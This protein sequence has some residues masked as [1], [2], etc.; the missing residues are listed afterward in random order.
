M[1]ELEAK[2]TPTASSDL[3]TWMNDPAM[4][5]MLKGLSVDPYEAAPNFD[6]WFDTVKEI[7]SS[8]GWNTYNPL[9]SARGPYQIL[10]GSYPVMLRRAIRAYKKAGVEPP[11]SFTDALADKDRDPADLSETE[12]RRLIFLDIQQRPQKNKEGVGTDKLIMDLAKGNWGAG[13]DLYLDHHHTD[14]TDQPTLKRSKEKFAEV[15]DQVVVPFKSVPKNLESKP[16]ESIKLGDLRITDEGFVTKGADSI[17]LGDLRIKDEEASQRKLEELTDYEA[18]F[19]NEVDRKKLEETLQ[20]VR[21][22]AQRVLEPIIPTKR[23]QVPIPQKEIEIDPVEKYLN[24]VI[25]PPRAGRFPEIEVD[26]QRV[27]EQALAKVSV[28]QRGGRFPEVTVDAQRVPE[29]ALAEVSVPQRELVSEQAL[30]PVSVPQRQRVSVP[31]R[32]TTRLEAEL[33]SEQMQAMQPD[34]VDKYLE[35]VV[36]AT[37]RLESELASAQMQAMQPVPTVTPS[38]DPIERYLNRGRVDK[39]E[40]GSAAVPTDPVEIY[41]ANKK[42]RQARDIKGALR[43]TAQGLTLGFGEELEALASGEEY[44]VALKRI[45]EE[46]DEFSQRSPRTALYGEVAG[47]LPT[48]LG[49]VNS[50]RALGVTSSAVAGGLEAGAYGLGVGEDTADR[51]EKGMYY[52]AGG[53]IVGRIFDSIFDPQLGRQVGSVDEL[54]KQKVNLQEQLLQEAKITRPTAELTNDELATQLLM[55]EVEYLGDA[56]GRQ[57]ALPSDLGSMLTRMRDYAIDMGVNM[58]QFNKVYNSNKDIKVLREKINEQFKDLEELSLLR[59]DLVDM[60]TGRLMKDVNTTIPQ[61]QSTVVKLRRLASPL[62]TLAEETVG[63]SFSERIIRGMNRVVRGQTALDKMWKGM[64]P[65]RELA[66]DNVKFNDALLD[67]MNSRLPQE[68]REKRLKAAMNI[69]RGKIGKG[70]EDRLNQ[71]LDD[72]LEFSARYR[73]EVTAGE[74]SRLWMHSNV[75]STAD[76]FSLRS[77][78]QKAQAKSEDAASKNIQRPSMQEWR[79]KNALQDVTKQKEYE[80][81]FDSHWRWQRQTLTRMELGKQLGFRTVGRP[82]VAEGKK[83]L[84]Q[85]AAKEAGSFKLFDDRII[86][87]ALKREGLSDVQISNA[88]QI[89]DD[90]GI[91]ANKGMSHELELIRSLGYVGTIANPYGALMNVHD[92]FNASFELGARNVLG[93]LFNKNNIVFNPEDMGLARQ[94]FGEFVRK[95]RKGTDQ[96]LLGERISGNKFLENAAQASESLLEWSMKWSGFSKLDQFGKSRIMGASFR[97]ARQDIADGSFDNKWQYSFSKPELDQLKRDIAAGNT[98]SEL[99]RD[100][101][102]FDLF[103]LQPINAAAQT[104]FGLANP[105]AR[106]FYM[107][108]GFA[109]KQFD[110]MERR[111]FKEWRDGNKK[112]ALENA[113]RYIVLSGGGYGLVNEGRQV[114]KGEVPDPEQAAMG[115]LY[116]IG[117]V[118]TFGAMGAND[119]GYDKFMSDPATSF[120]NNILPPVGA[121]LP[122]AVLKDTASVARA[123]IAGEIPDP[124]PDESLEALP[125]VGKT[126]KGITEE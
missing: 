12:V 58:K 53:A 64:E 56:V 91:N 2:T 71:F 109:I 122:A 27:P 17:K 13:Q 77:F 30:G 116:Q 54:N 44:G 47:A 69:A 75:T 21:V 60:T 16:I 39:V 5:D 22:D 34:P 15:E 52:G 88:K 72:N 89:I 87:E 121:T 31:P 43:V 65:F 84:E 107:L 7:E 97:K 98:S 41:F 123:L 110:L 106:L 114:I 18:T 19:P 118:F 70:A 81:I 85:T 105:N 59:Q 67:V 73:R 83:T 28:P 37:P 126:I 92:L 14:R 8:G 63:R 51:L 20:E 6:L 11:K 23:G 38:V 26:A 33:A 10:K 9:S 68:F 55:R 49:I 111:I 117:S 66:Q 50:L 35:R 42:E 76:D 120:M 1:A 61:A 119:Y 25:V 95:A 78:R 93:A 40:L 86:E 45:R 112:Q 46:M 103:R 94:V 124:I 108:K 90:L 3:P 100:L 80:N 79:K 24:R 82:L 104:A 62:A 113:M 36:A 29:Q 57:G 96:K 74:L 125:L 101:V 115:A 32:S 48:S 102:M 99:V 4:L